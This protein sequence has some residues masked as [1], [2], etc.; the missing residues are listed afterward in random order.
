MWINVNW[1]M[2]MSDNKHKC[3]KTIQ[4]RPYRLS[5]LLKSLDCRRFYCS[6]I[7]NDIFVW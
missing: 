2:Y 7:F 6:F 5:L 3:E 4:K 1:N